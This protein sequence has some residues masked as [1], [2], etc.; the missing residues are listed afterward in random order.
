MTACG[1]SKHISRFLISTTD[2]DQWQL[3]VWPLYFQRRERL[4][5]LNRRQGELQSRAGLFWKTGKP[6]APRGDRDRQKRAEGTLKEGNKEREN[7][8]N[9]EE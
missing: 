1:E 3:H 5:A 4:C 7:E 8:G 6:L 2:A 9:K